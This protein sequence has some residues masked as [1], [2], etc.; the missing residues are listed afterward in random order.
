MGK[1]KR[2]KQ[3]KR[4]MNI[5]THSFGFRQPYQVIVDGNF[6]HVCRTTGKKLDEIL[7][8]YLGGPAR[9][10][11]T[12][13]VYAELRKLGPEMRPSAAL[14]K[15]LEKRRCTHSPAV[16]AKECITELLGNENKFRYCVATQDQDLRIHL[17]KIPGV[18][19][20]YINKSVTILEPVSKATQK[21]ALEVIIV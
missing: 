14:A 18:P 19:L 10:M 9:I 1:L 11:T 17:R 2:Q 12:Y 20:I 5:Y 8:L 21:H 15:K 3:N 6:I 13:C 7:P 4:N 16:T